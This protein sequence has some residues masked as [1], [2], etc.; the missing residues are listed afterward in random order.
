M[1][2]FSSVHSAGSE[3]PLSDSVVVFISALS[4]GA[5]TNSMGRNC[6]THYPAILPLSYRVREEPQKKC[7]GQQFPKSF[8]Q[9][10]LNF[11]RVISKR[12][13]SISVMPCILS[14][15]VLTPISG[16]PDFRKL[17]N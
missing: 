14:L 6:E 5:G 8:L 11:Q 12:V 16:V 9:L 2:G 3:T 13:C 15:S 7:P 4:E 17:P 1:Q 10:L